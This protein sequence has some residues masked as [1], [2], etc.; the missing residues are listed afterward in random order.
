VLERERADTL[1]QYG[2]TMLKPRLSVGAVPAVVGCLSAL[3]FSWFMRPDVQPQADRQAGSQPRTSLSALELHRIRQLE[4]QLQALQAAQ[5]DGVSARAGN[6]TKTDANGYERAYIEES[7]GDAHGSEKAT[8]LEMGM[9]PSTPEEALAEYVAY[10]AREEEAFA[11]DAPDTTW[12]A[13]AAYQLRA[14][15]DTVKDG[16][17]FAVS[18]YAC[19]ATRCRAELYFESAA[20][21]TEHS[22]RLAEMQVPGLNCARTT[23]IDPTDENRTLLFLDC[24]DLRAGLAEAL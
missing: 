3:L 12:S 6:P 24:S 16:L 22:G 8:E 21:A 7:D 5:R 18:S 14:Q 2:T 9:G 15:L 13:Q 19:K 4:E 17:G 11:N 10:V 1:L 20:N 23:T